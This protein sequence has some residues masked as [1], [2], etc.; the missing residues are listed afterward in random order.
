[1]DDGAT[2]SSAEI[3]ESYAKSDERIS[4]LHKQNGGLSSAR[5][6]GFEKCLG[7]YVYFLDS[8]DYLTNNAVELLVD[9]TNNSPDI[10]FFDA[11]TFADA[12]YN[13]SYKADGYIRSRK[14]PDDTG[15]NMA[16][17][18]FNSK[19]FHYSVPL[20]FLKR[21]FLNDNN[22]SFK[23]KIINEDMIFTFEAFIKANMVKHINK[24]LYHRRFRPGSIVTSKKRM[25]SYESALDI[26]NEIKIFT[27]KCEKKNKD[28]CTKYLVGRALTVIN[29]FDELESADREK[30]KRQQEAFIKDVRQNNGFG[31]R[32]LLY[33]CDSKLKWFIYKVYKKIF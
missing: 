8:D 22:L 6:A 30:V 33:R 19:E 26:Y 5:N 17:S 21:E 1:M 31:D 16:R 7:E 10:V 11:I 27:D 18:L 14:Y 15:A 12:D 32:A 3:C 9:A 23:E 20:L 25:L 4:V 2:D 29:K 13:G 24:N 28:V